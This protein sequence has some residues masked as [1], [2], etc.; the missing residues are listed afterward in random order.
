MKTESNVVFE[1]A[2]REAISDSLR[3]MAE[4]YIDKAQNE[5]RERLREEIG[6]VAVRL[7]KEVSF[8]D[9]GETLRIEV[10]QK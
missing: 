9:L 2:I 8:T 5:L 7:A 4:E 3:L 10:H 6:K 1:A